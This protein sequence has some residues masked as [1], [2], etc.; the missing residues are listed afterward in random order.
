MFCFFHTDVFFLLC[1]F[2]IWSLFFLAAGEFKYLTRT[3]K[4]ERRGPENYEFAISSYPSV[5]ARYIYCVLFTFSLTVSLSA[6][7]TKQLE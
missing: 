3:T 6:M 7:R 2:E 5:I 4:W 1:T